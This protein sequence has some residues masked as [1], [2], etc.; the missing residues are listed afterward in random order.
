MYCE[1]YNQ[2]T[3][4]LLRIRWVTATSP[5]TDSPGACPLCNRQTKH[6]QVGVAGVECK[7]F[8]CS[9]FTTHTT[10]ATR[11]DSYSDE[12]SH[13]DWGRMDA[14]RRTNDSSFVAILGPADVAIDANKSN[15]FNN[16]RW[17][18]TSFPRLSF[19]SL[20]L[21]GDR[22]TDNKRLPYLFHPPTTIPVSVS[23]VSLVSW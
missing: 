11:V 6:Q 10:A 7:V 12:D 4:V 20:N 8:I 3:L 2:V 16:L 5:P 13:I 14:G 1:L 23:K 18:C 9:S 15:R 17:A 19:P 22:S 21:Q